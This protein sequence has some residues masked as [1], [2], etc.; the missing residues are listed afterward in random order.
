MPSRKKNFTKE[1]STPI[2]VST[3]LPTFHLLPRCQRIHQ[4]MRQGRNKS[5]TVMLMR[6]TTMRVSHPST[7]DLLLPFLLS[8]EQFLFFTGFDIVCYVNSNYRVPVYAHE[9]LYLLL[10]HFLHLQD[11]YFLFTLFSC[12]FSDL[13]LP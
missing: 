3:Q 13:L 5:T 8:H 9:L 6:G 11:C 4:W 1:S 2:C 10:C 7:L 12:A